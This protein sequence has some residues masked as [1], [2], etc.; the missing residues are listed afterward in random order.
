MN[1]S[2]ILTEKLQ[3]RTLISDVESYNST[4]SLM[5]SFKQETFAITEISMSEDGENVIRGIIILG[6][7]SGR[8]CIMN[9]DIQTEFSFLN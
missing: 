1:I 5:E 6:V 3:G 8:E 4:V 9:F 2:D 7:N